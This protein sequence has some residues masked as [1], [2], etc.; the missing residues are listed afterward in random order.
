MTQPAIPVRGS[1]PSTR[2]RRTRRHDWIRNL[3]R[4]TTLSADHL[5]W[6]LFVCEGEGVREAV[7]SMPG[8]NRYSIDLCLEQVGRAIEFGI[9]AIAL[10]PKTP[11]TKKTAGAEEATNPNNLMCSA[12]RAIRAKYG[13]QIGLVADVALDPYTSHGHDGLVVND[14]VV[15]DQTIEILCRQAVVQAEAGA[16]VIAPSDMM[17]GR[18]GSIRNALDDSGHHGVLLMSYAAKYASA[19]YGPF[20]DAVGSAGNLG[21]ATK[22]TYQMDPAA[23]DEAL[24]E[25]ALDLQEGAD[26][27]MV[28]PGMPYLDIVRRLRDTF[29]VPIAIYQVSGE[30]A[31]L[32]AAAQNGWL[33]RRSVVLESLLSMRRAGANMILTYFAL[34]VAHYLRGE[35][36][37]ADQVS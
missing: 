5:I 23:S 32:T 1:F 33:D 31:M 27:V 15:N 19:F 21:K 22:K 12:L 36:Y 34:E 3:V 2:M 17:D 9:P 35:E 24:H 4:E 14:Y 29:A 25:V 6:P 37:V 11:V 28:K 26:I 8:V 10:F 13:D 30:Y 16:S 7:P 20:R 18:I